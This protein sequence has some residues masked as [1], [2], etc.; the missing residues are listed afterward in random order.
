[1]VDDFLRVA[2]LLPGYSRS[3]IHYSKDR[4]WVERYKAGDILKLSS[5]MGCAAERSDFVHAKVP[6][7]YF[8]PS[9]Q[10][11]YL[12]S[13]ITTPPEREV[14]VMP[15]SEFKVLHSDGVAIHVCDL[16]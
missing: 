2:E 3:F 16:Y 15:G 1:M 11:R 13:L 14:I 10:V 9:S 7:V 4:K 8:E 5:F 12:G 6:R